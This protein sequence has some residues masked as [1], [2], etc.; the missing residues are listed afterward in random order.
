MFSLGTVLVVMAAIG[1][2]PLLYAL[3]RIALL[4]RITAAGCRPVL[5]VVGV[6]YLMLA[7]IAATPFEVNAG[8]ASAAPALAGVICV[9]LG[10][11]T[12]SHKQSSTDAQ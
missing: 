5:Y 4:M 11:M 6:A 3:A 10:W 8:W 1:G 2:P 7:L 12:G 9:T